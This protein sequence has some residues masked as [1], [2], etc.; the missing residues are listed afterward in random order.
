MAKNFWKMAVEKHFRIFWTSI[1]MHEK[2][3]VQKNSI[4]SEVSQ[5]E[6]K[7]SEIDYV[8]IPDDVDIVKRK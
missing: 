2:I 1:F 4:L 3:D 7:L 5:F 8:D 6:P